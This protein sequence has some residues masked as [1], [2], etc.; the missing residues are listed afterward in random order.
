[1]P[2]RSPV[3]YLLHFAEPFKHARHYVGYSELLAQ[4]LAHHRRGTGA[5]LMAAVSAAGIEV[6]VARVWRGADR[7]FERRVHNRKQSAQLCPMCSGDSALG[8]ATLCRRP[9][10]AP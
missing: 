7:T 8:R 5:R 3:V 9:A 10:G 2:R 1:M 6:T 4:R